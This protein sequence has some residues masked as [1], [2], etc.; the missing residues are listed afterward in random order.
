MPEMLSAVPPVLVN[1]IPRVL[2][3]PNLV[4]TEP[5]FRASGTSSTVPV[6][7]SMAVLADF[8]LSSTEAAVSVTTGLAGA[9]E[10]AV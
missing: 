6:L 2:E 5:K 7:I 4:L 9:V 3:P 8:V 1:V 10:G